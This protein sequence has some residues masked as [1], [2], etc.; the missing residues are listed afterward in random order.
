M[1]AEVTR[2]IASVGFC[3]TGSGTSVDAHVAGLI[4]HCC[5]HGLQSTVIRRG[6]AVAVLPGN[7]STPHELR[8]PL[9]VD[10]VDNRTNIRDFLTSR[11]AR[12]NPS[13]RG[14]PP[15]PACAVSPGC[16]GRRWRCWPAS[17]STTTPASSA[18]IWRACPKACSTLWH[19]RCNSTTPNATTS[20]TWPA[21]PMRPRAGD[22][23]TARPDC[24]PACSACSMRSP[25]RRHG[26]TTIAW[27]SSAANRLGYALYSEMFT[28]PV[29]PVNSARFMFLNPRSRDFYPR[30]GTRSPTT[31][32]PSCAAR[33]AATPTTRISPG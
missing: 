7:G 12:V 29:R 23:V 13:R 33:P 2:T 24:G 19:K 6:V 20:S 17:A 28:D 27:T 14:C 21:R 30:L 3:R 32:S 1:Q 9:T 5:S 8:N 18:A 11:R 10:G 16:A 15:T 4:H 31:Q 22:A 25:L 26:C